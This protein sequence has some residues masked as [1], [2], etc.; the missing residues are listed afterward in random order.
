MAKTKVVFIEGAFS[1]LLRKNPKLKEVFTDEAEKVR[2]AAQATAQAAQNGPG[3]TIYGYAEAGF[4]WKW[5]ARG[6]RPRVTITSNADPEMA[7][8]AHFYTQKRDG[9]AH[10]RAALATITKGK[11]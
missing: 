9:I 2:N 8:R 7:L 3:G 4:T 1:E 6:N 11:A 5:E 10:L